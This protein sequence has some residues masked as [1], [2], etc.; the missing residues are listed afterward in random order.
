MPS[1]AETLRSSSMW[2]GVRSGF[3]ST[4]ARLRAWVSS[5]LPGDLRAAAVDRP[6]PHPGRA[7]DVAVQQD[8]QLRLLLVGLPWS[9][10]Q[11]A[12]SPPSPARAIRRIASCK[13]RGRRSRARRSCRRSSSQGISPRAVSFPSGLVSFSSLISYPGGIGRSPASICWMICA[14]P[15]LTSRNSSRATFCNFSR[16]SLIFA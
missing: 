3:C 9:I 13:T 5:K 10:R 2:T 14:L 4:L 6:V 7:H 16:A 12:G 1:V 11:I 8:R 15:G